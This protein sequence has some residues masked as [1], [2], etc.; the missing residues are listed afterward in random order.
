MP[1]HFILSA[2]QFSDHA[3]QAES[4]P[5]FIQFQFQTTFHLT[6]LLAMKSLGSQPI[7][8]SLQPILR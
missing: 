4:F 7:K 1:Y 3:K 8:P 2:A 5:Y 6:P